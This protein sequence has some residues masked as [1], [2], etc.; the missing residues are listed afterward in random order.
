MTDKRIQLN[1][2]EIDRVAGGAGR[3]PI[4][5]AGRPGV[6]TGTGDVS[7]GIKNGTDNTSNSIK[8]AADQANPLRQPNP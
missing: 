4:Q 8:N 5:N 3:R 1:D 6:K 7:G 2:S